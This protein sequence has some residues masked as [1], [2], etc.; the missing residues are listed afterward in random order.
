MN[1][2]GELHPTGRCT[3]SRGVRYYR[4]GESMGSRVD[5]HAVNKRKSLLPC[6]D[7]ALLSNYLT[8]NLHYMKCLLIVA[9]LKS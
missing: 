1:V 9:R 6:G 7:E 8:S 3:F 5:L 2:C 4:I